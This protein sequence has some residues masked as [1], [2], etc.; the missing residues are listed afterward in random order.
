MSNADTSKMIA[1]K[2]LGV[3]ETFRV[4]DADMSIGEAVAFL[5]VALGETGGEGGLTVTEIGQ[6]GGFSLASASRYIQSLN[7]KNRHGR[8]GHELV[9]DP[10]D[11]MDD[12]RKVLRLTPKGR[13]IL[14]QIDAVIGG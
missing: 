2:A 7:K 11:P 14:S 10:R 12:R 6:Q 5:L 9:T 4:L 13:R 1:R 8:D 3:L